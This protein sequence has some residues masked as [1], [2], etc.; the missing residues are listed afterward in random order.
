MSLNYEKILSTVAAKDFIGR[1]RETSAI[2]SHAEGG[3]SKARGLLLISAPA[4]GAS[5]I[6]KQT[7]D[8]LFQ[9]QNETIPFYFS[10]KNSDKT[11]KRAALR[12]L[13]GFLQQTV[14]FRRKDARILDFGGGAE[15]LAE[16]AVPSDGY[17][18]DRVIESVRPENH[19]TDECAFIRNCLSAPLRAYACGAKSFVMI[20]NLHE[21]ENLAGEIDFV[22]QVKEVFSGAN[23][24]FVL[25]G[26]RRFISTVTAGF[27]DAD[28]LQIEPLSFTEAGLFAENLSEQTG[29]KI[30][31]QTRDLIATQF[32][33]NPTFIKFLFQAASE[34]DFDLDSFQ[35]VEQIYV[36]ELFGG[37][38]G[39]FY[40]RIFQEITPFVETQK[41]IIGLLYDALTVEKEKSPVESWQKRVGLEEKDFYRAMRLLNAREIIRLTSNLVEAMEENEVLS[42]YV[43]ARFRL[44]TIA[45]NRAL[46]VGETLSEFLKR[47]PQTMARFYRRSSA[48]GLRELLSV[49]DC[50]ET[51]LALVDY[52]KFKNE[53]KGAPNAEILKDL[54]V[55]ESEKIVLP[56]IVYTAH[57]VAFYPTIVQVTERE[58]SAVALGFEESKYT[59]E[60]EIVWIAA[61]IDSKLEASKELAEFWCDRLE[62]VALVCNFLKYRLW[63]IA[64]EGFAPE[65]IEV[66]NQRNAFGSSKKQVELL[67]E[68][69]DARDVLGEKT[70]SNEYEM[71]V[72]MGE[73]TEMIAAQTIE[74]IARRHRFAPKA[75]NQIKTALLEACIN[76]AE[77]S[78]SP[79]RKIY[80]KFTV[81]D[82]KIVITIS[83]RGLRLADKNAHEIAPNEGR[84]GWGLKLMK[85]LMDEVKLEQV[86]D[87]TRISMVKYLK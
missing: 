32:Q 33:G 78:Y 13:Q 64:P 3:E 29:V 28:V 84:R 40:D 22:E 59:D 31:E 41:N 45:E 54:R 68:F 53:Y 25:A 6:L 50:Q 87:G 73:D 26:G 74:E 46:V 79:D 47:A 19:L 77:H 24:S 85:T 4:L 76:A 75:I 20:D 16:L 66:L 71:I 44:E 49:F 8:S 55:V 62:M 23:I 65:A 7:Y 43:T 38:I 58:R 72:P 15:E 80:Q 83:N 52:A 35:K 37:R 36:D 56:Q 2:L 63:L 42:D 48:I 86:D 67:I 57:T 10:L 69:L 30:N 82:D 70:K 21:A 81:E 51:P 60:G 12:F 39:K 27:G 9:S 18:I 5:E 11:A 1:T 17:W 14:A 34:K 61:E